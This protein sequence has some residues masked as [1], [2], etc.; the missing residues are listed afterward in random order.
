MRKRLSLRS[1]AIPIA[2]LGLVA[3]GLAALNAAA[4]NSGL[5]VSDCRDATGTY[6]V[7]MA[8]RGGDSSVTSR[9]LLSLS[10]DGQAILIDANQDGVA[11]FGPYS[12]AAGAWTCISSNDQ[13]NEVSVLML[14]FTFITHEHPAQQIGR[15]TIDATIDASQD[16]LAGTLGFSLLPLDGNPLGEASGEP[17]LSGPITGQRV[18]APERG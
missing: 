5:S 8:G 9:G 10:S 16:S 15:I 11:G 6:F 12:T 3:V 14:H 17:S 18:E 1:S 7:S 4:Q 2:T 13:S